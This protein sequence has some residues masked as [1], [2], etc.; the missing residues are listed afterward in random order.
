MFKRI[1]EKLSA[2]EHKVHERVTKIHVYGGVAG[3]LFFLDTADGHIL[4]GVGVMVLAVIDL[5]DEIGK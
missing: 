2:A 4:Y 5:R 3:T 1:G